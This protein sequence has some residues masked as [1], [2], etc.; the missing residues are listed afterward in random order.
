[1]ARL[2]KGYE[3]ERYTAH[4]G[5]DMTPTM[6]AALDR[7][8]ANAGLPL[9]EFARRTLLA[10]R[11]GPAPAP[12]RPSLDPKTATALLGELGKIGSNI[13]QMAR[14]ANQAGRIPEVVVLQAISA[15]LKAVLDR[16]V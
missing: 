4:F 14:R 1:M 5:F 7:K 6:R 15:Q 10:D 12:S 13:N 8:A 9:A 11:A 16:I 2:K 3:G